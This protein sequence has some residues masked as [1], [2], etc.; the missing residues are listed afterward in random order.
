MKS[1]LSLIMHIVKVP[2]QQE[3]AATPLC[4]RSVHKEVARVTRIQ[5][6]RNEGAI[7][8]SWIL[9]WTIPLLTDGKALFA[10]TLNYSVYCQGGYT[11][12]NLPQSQRESW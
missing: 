11:P 3:L 2:T 5:K 7:L 6:K 8:G 9:H 1:L 10:R 12:C 4:F